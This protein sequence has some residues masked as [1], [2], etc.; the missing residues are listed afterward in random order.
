M[1]PTPF[2]NPPRPL[3]TLEQLHEPTSVPEERVVIHDVDW[4]FYEQLVDSIP[5][6]AGIHAD[7]DGKDIEI[8]SLSGLHDVLKKAWV[9]S[10]NWSPR[11]SRSLARAWDRRPGSARRSLAAWK[12]TNATASRP[13][14][15]R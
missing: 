15:S 11:N 1:P 12:P 5:P 8:M 10:R 7:Y 3:P 13:T 9:V 4:A 2:P 14:S 6:R